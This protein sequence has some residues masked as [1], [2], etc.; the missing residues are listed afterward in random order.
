[1]WE[2]GIKTDENQTDMTE[3]YRPKTNKTKA[4]LKYQCT[5]SQPNYHRRTGSDLRL[6][7]EI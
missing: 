6:K 4:S 3:I 7:F 1:M 5:L 2:E